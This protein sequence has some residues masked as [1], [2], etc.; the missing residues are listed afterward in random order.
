ME[1]IYLYSFS[2]N[3]VPFNLGTA[4]HKVTAIDKY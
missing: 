1:A 2:I 4:N 3:S